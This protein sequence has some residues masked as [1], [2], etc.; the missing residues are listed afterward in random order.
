MP[1]ELAERL[2]AEAGEM[3]VAYGEGRLSLPTALADYVPAWFVI[4]VA[5]DEREARRARSARPRRKR[6]AGA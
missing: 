3:L 4:K 1:V 5:L 6:G 2:T